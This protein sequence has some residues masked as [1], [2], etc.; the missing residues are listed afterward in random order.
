MRKLEQKLT[1][2][3]KNKG[4]LKQA[5]AHGSCRLELSLQDYE[6]YERLELL[7]DSVVNFLTTEFLFFKYEKENEGSL[8]K[9]KAAIVSGKALAQAAKRLDLSSY[10]I[11]ANGVDKENPALLADVF[12]SLIGAVYLDA[13]IEKCR[14]IVS[15]YLFSKENEILQS[16][17]FKNPKTLLN[18]KIQELALGAPVYELLEES[19]E[20]HR[21]EFKVAVSAGG[22]RLGTGKGF[23]KKEAEQHAAKEALENIGQKT[24]KQG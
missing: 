5:F 17:I 12:E 14:E 24:E 10:L 6:T 13:G 1:C 16:D 22:K 7:G 15:K 2:S 18:E 4:L 3:F 21:R 19:G 8:A 11:C 23:T 20:I 9:K